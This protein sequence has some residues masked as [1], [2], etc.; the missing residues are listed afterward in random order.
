MQL[1]PL[2]SET[3]WRTGYS[4]KVIIGIIDLTTAGTSQTLTIFPQK[5][6]MYYGAP[7]TTV[8][9]NPTQLP[10]G[11]TVKSAAVNFT[12]LFTGPS[13]SS[14]QVSVGDAGSATRQ[15]NGTNTDGFTTG[16]ANSKNPVVGGTK[17]SFT[18][19]DVAAN[20]LIQAAFTSAGCNLSA[21]TG[22]VVEIYLELMDFNEL[23]QVIEPG[24][25]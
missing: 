23:S 11:F 5:E 16:T 19:A 6:L 9:Q 10:A 8:T 12:T 14:L 15:I 17:Y 1:I 20:S 22:G 25:P 18:P 13:L 21:L 4:H 3:Q 7:P 24:A 2:P